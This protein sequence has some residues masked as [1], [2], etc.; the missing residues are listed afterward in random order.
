MAEH[1]L[2]Q[3]GEPR[4]GEFADRQRPEPLHLEINNWQHIMDLI[5][6]QYKMRGS[7]DILVSTL[8]NSASEGGLG[9]KGLSRA[10]EDHYKNEKTR[11]KKFTERLIGQQAVTLARHGLLLIDN[12]I[13]NDESELERYSRSALS[14]VLETLRNIG[15]LINKVDADNTYPN[16]VTITCTLY[17]NL[18]ALF[19]PDYSN[20]TVWT[21]GYVIPYHACKLFYEYKVGYGILS[22]QGKE[23]KNS[24]VKQELKSCT[25]RNKSEGEKNKWHQLMK[26][27]YVRNFYLQSRYPISNYRPHYNSRIPP[28]KSEGNS[29][30]PYCHREIIESVEMCDMC[31]CAVEYIE[32]VKQGV[33]P[34]FICELLKPYI[35]E[36]CKKR[37]ADICIGKHDCNTTSMLIPK[38]MTVEELRCELKKLNL[39]I[40]G[41]KNVLCERLENHI[42][43]DK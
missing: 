31:M 3:L 30:C 13:T 19:F 1:G 10:I 40:T 5:Y 9:L 39:P 24:A 16:E 29:Y 41:S 26:S 25:N 23:A 6:V 22:M 34:Q 14:K 27:N 38:N 20:S 7:V 18:I 37:F 42:T 35:C 8:R 43:F 17:F 4:I 33:L 28:V 2:R 36:I 11:D 21:M 32:Y 12:L 15:V